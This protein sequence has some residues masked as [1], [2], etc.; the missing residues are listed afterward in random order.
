MQVRLFDWEMVDLVFVLLDLF[1]STTQMPS[2][3]VH[4]QYNVDKGDSVI[5]FLNIEDSPILNIAVEG[6]EDVAQFELKATEIND[7]DRMDESDET[8]TE[9][10]DVENKSQCQNCGNMILKGSFQMHVIVCERNNKKC[11]KC[12]KIIKRTEFDRHWH[13]QLCDKVLFIL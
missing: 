6:C 8:Q 11:D 10:V 2:L 3:L 7:A 5:E 12:G 9:D 4:D 1:V 13:C